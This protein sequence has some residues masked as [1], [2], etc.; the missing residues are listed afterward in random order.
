M[1][2]SYDA[3]FD[4][5]EFIKRFFEYL[6]VYTSIL[7]TPAMDEIVVNI[8]MEIL[9]TFALATKDLKQ[10]RKSESVSCLTSHIAQYNAVK[11]VRKLFGEK[12]VEAV[13]QRLD[14]LSQDEARMTAL[15]ILEVIS[16][17]FHNMKL[18][19]NGEK[20]NTACLP[21]TVDYIF[22]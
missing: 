4:L 10:G 13:L 7:P 18:V 2:A 5:L 17:L 9:S 1:S 19:M 14:R 11:D 3:L 15:Q 20:P 8:M 6:E 22:L 16:G 12:M 21:L